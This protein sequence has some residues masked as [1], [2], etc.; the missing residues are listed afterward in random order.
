MPEHV[1]G[2]YYSD[3]GLVTFQCHKP[4]C[5]HSLGGDPPCPA[6]DAWRRFQAAA[7]SEG[8]CPDHPQCRLEP[9]D[10]PPRPW[11]GLQ[12]HGRCPHT[13]IVH[14]TGEH[15][16]VGTWIAEDYPER[17]RGYNTVHRW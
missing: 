11:P 14:S 6:Y 9:C 1:T 5:P 16:D 15:A 10:R 7:V 3:A 17:L 2:P 8:F 13:G 4:D 12:A